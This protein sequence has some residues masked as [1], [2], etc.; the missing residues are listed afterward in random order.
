MLSPTRMTNS[1][2]NT[3]CDFQICAATSYCG[4]SPVPVSPSTAKRREFGAVGGI[5]APATA[6]GGV[7]GLPW[8]LVATGDGTA[9]VVA[10]GVGEFRSADG[11]T[12]C[13]GI[14]HAPTVK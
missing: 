11:S 5:V 12:L 7:A 9:G 1:Y 6:A 14:A 10:A 3:A 13:D 2:G 4:F 8:A